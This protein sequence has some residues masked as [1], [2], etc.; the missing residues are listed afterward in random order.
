MPRCLRDGRIFALALLCL[1][2]VT[3][4]A[5]EEPA[6]PYV[7]ASPIHR[8]VFDAADPRFDELVARGAV[9]A[10][11]DYGAFLVAKVDER[12]LGG[13]EAFLATDLA[14]EDRL[15]VVGFNDA[16]FDTA[17]AAATERAF[18]AIPPALRGDDEPRRPGR[19][20]VV[21]QFDGPIKDAWLE[22]L[23]PT[24]AKIVTYMAENAYV[25]SVEESARAAFEA[26]AKAPFVAWTGAY[27]PWFK[28]SPDL[29]DDAARG[30]GVVEATVQVV[31]DRD[32]AALVDGLLA[33]F[34]QVRPAEESPPYVNLHL[35]LTGATVASLA[36]HPSVFAIEK[37]YPARLF[38]EVQGQIVAG[39][40]NAAGTAPTGTGYFAWLT[41]KGFAQAGQFAFAV[42]VTDDGVDRGSLT[43]VN[44]EFKVG[45]AA[46]GA[47]RVVYN[48]NYTGDASADGGAGHGNINASIVGGYNTLTGAAYEDASAYNY[49]LGICPFVN[50]GNT[51]VFSNGSAATFTAAATTRLNAAYA[52]GARISSNSWGYTSGNSY[53]SDTQSHDNLV[54]DA[55][56]GVGGNQELMIVF[57]AGNSGSGANTVAPPAT[58]K[59]IFCVGASENVRQTGTDG[60]GTANSGANSAMD[61]IGFSSRG[62]CSD[63]RKKPDIMAPGTHIQGAASRS[64][65]Y[66]GAGVCNQYWPAGQTLYCWSSGTSHSTPA[67]SGAAALTRQYFLN[68]GWGTPSPAMVKAAMMTTTRYL[69]GVG[70]NDTLYSNNQ[71][72]GLV[73][74]GRLY[75]GSANLRTDQTQVFGATGQTYTV[76]GSVTNSALPF[77]VG[78]VWTDKSGAT[79]G[80]AWVNNLNLSVTVGGQTY[81]GNVFSGA[82]STTG[83]AADASN[84]AEFVFRPAGVTGAFTITVTAANVAGDGVPG[85]ADTTD[86]DFALFVYNGSGAASPDF[87][88]SA[89]PATASVNAGAA[90]NY[91]VSSTASGGFASPITYSVAPAVTGVTYAFSANPAAAGAATTLTAT[92]SASTPAGTY[93]LTVTGTGGGLTRTTNVSLT[94]VAPNFALT[95][96]PTTR[97]IA[98]GASTTYA[99]TSTPSGGFASTVTLSASPAIAGATYAFSTNPI[100][101]NGTSTLTVTT[102]AATPA[103][104]YAITVTGV[105][106]GLTRTTVVTLV[107]QTP[108]FTLTATPTTRTIAQGTATTYVMSTAASGGFA[109]TVSLSASPAIAG[110]TYAF[111]VNPAPA[112]GTSVLTVSTGATTPVGTYAITVTGTGG[113][114]TRTAALTLVVTAAGGGNQVKTNG[115]TPNLAIPD[116]NAT[117]VTSTVNFTTSQTI[118]SVSVKVGIT[119]TYIG[120]LIVTL[121]GPTGLQK[122]LHNRTGGSADNIVTTYS[123]QT[124]PNQALTGYVGLNTAGNWQLKVQDMAGTDVGTL[125]SWSITFNGEV[126]ATPNLA[127]PDNNATGITSS[128]VVGGTGTLA[129][130]VVKVGITHTYQGDLQ[131]TLVHPDGTQIFLHNQTG[132]SADNINT[133]YPTLTAPAAALT[134][135]NGKPTNGTWQLKVKDLAAADTGVLNSWT[136]CLGVANAP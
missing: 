99:L 93:A 136:L 13:R 59:N 108:N 73:D 134:A 98:Q 31:A 133:I 87:S 117:G 23:A 80:N 35:R 57:A 50:L 115:A 2:S 38:D 91:A 45:G 101:A 58:G 4:S 64:L 66:N 86:Q 27:R 109:S 81:L 83:G 43:D 39:N 29:R 75:D 119:H 62:P 106:G 116:N 107:V 71:G 96:S 9:A 97:T 51:K 68:Q 24:G 42:D 22:A 53:N 76:S 15:G 77:R 25:L 61:V 95:S 6:P 60:C 5:Q 122:I 10:F 90:A 52:G 124:A 130:V 63:G 30:T 85:N 123:I 69:N 3:A 78:L 113:G 48:N 21:L 34:E 111:S 100:A 16:A 120:D 40:L 1:S 127:I 126:S 49:G 105:G 118:T 36:Q 55:Q 114:L 88:L 125:N 129:S 56:T 11:H 128:V 37:L 132:G 82:N 103:A 47:S 17:D 104:T 89:T 110:A 79:T 8:V 67:I 7:S 135:L 12:V 18:A 94:V 32:A 46:A 41:S 14:V 112:T 74:L 121:I 102:T 72:M 70:A 92:T 20:L 84:N 26:Y 131:V 28:V 44:T 19:R 33:T 65:V 54:R